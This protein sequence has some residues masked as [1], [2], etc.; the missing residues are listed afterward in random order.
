MT[1]PAEARGG[2]HGRRAVPALRQHVGRAARPRPSRRARAAA[3]TPVELEATG[4][5]TLE[6][7]REYAGTGVDYLSRGGA[8]PLSPILDI[9]LDLT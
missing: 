5:L 1:T 3:L 2:G 9:A 8:D 7:A 6:V 4:G